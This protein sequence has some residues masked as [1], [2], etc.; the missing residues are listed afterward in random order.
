[1]DIQLHSIRSTTV[2]DLKGGWGWGVDGGSKKV[3]AFVSL[4]VVIQC[5]QSV[6]T[7]KWKRVT[8]PAHRLQTAGVQEETRFHAQL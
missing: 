6:M 2:S 1:M 3:S 7:A 4:S 8:A 5:E